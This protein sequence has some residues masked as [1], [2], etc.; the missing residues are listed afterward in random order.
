MD[1]REIKEFIRDFSI[2][3]ITLFIIVFVLVFIVSFRPIAGNS[4]LPSLNDGDIT[5]VSKLSYLF[6]EPKRND[7]VVVKV[8]GKYYVKR[9]VGL[10]GEDISYLKNVLYIN[11]MPYKEGFLKKGTI[12]TGFVMKDIC[13]KGECIDNKIPED[14]YLLLG[15]NREESLDSRSPDFGLVSIKDIKGKVFLRVF[16][17]SNFGKVK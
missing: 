3:F 14:K 6:S 1:L 5:L 12:T 4:M 2:Y 16:P 17:I 7:I 11:N 8:E 9:I 13:K 10:P 15:D